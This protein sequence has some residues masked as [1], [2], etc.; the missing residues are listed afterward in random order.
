MIYYFA[1]LIIVIVGV[2][3]VSAF[4]IFGGTRNALKNSVATFIVITFLVLAL[5]VDWAEPGWCGGS[6]GC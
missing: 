5:A 4:I 2:A 1:A 6:F 3:L